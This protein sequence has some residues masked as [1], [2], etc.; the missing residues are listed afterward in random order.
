MSDQGRPG[1]DP[2]VI[3]VGGGGDGDGDGGSSS[4]SSGGSSGG[5]SSAP[6]DPQGPYRSILLGMRLPPGLFA[7]LLRRAVAEHWTAN[8]FLWALSSAKQFNRMFPGIQ[9]LLDQGMSVTQ[10][11]TTWRATSEAYEQSLR[12]AGLWGFVKGKMNKQNVGQAIKNG[13]DPEEM[14]F[15]VSIAEQA[16]RSEALRNSFNAI[17]KN[18]GEQQLDKKGWVRFLMGKSD[19]R[20]YDM[21]E[22]AQLLQTLGGVEGLRV[23]EAR[24]L[25]KAFGQPGQFVD[26]T[27]AIGNI[28]RVRR[29]LGTQTLRDAGITAKDEAL[30]AL[31]DSL[32]ARN[33]QM[34]RKAAGLQSRIEQLLANREASEAAGGQEA[35]SIVSGRPISELGPKT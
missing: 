33:P 28:D 6:A 18:K 13:V 31:A 16:R 2:I 4:S 7:D 22:G 21:Y 5:G 26:V 10:A 9:S 14:V 30:V 20:L 3:N 34:R 12:D 29:T 11:V 27:D 8:D 1:D 19:A 32:T 23:K 15:R 35:V 24:R 17:L 25:A